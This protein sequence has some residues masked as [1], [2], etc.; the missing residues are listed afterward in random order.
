MNVLLAAALPA[1]AGGERKF[2][3]SYRA[4][5]NACW[6]DRE[7]RQAAFSQKRQL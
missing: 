7:S 6:R 3:L 2:A 4:C 5:P 1:A